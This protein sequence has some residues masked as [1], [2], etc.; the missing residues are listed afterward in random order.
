MDRDLNPIMCAVCGCVQGRAGR[1]KTK[2]VPAWLPVRSRLCGPLTVV[3]IRNTAPY[4]THTD[5]TR[6][7]R[8]DSRLERLKND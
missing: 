1:F 3:Y 7:L 5:G 6:R 2:S 4:L 8:K